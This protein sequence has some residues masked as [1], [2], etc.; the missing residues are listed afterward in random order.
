MQAFAMAADEKFDAAI[1]EDAL[2]N[3][4]KLQYELGGGAFNGAINLLSRYLE[5]YSSSP[6]APEART[7][8]IAAYYNSHDYDAAY[9]AIKAMPTQDADIRA[10]LQKISYFRGWRPTKRATWPPHGAT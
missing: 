5:R 9:R 6:R 3:Y 2:F 8:L 1:A 7:L 10:A 4:A